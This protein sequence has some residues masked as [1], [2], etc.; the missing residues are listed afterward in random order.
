M[1]LEIL[2]A[3]NVATAVLATL[4]KKA[5]DKGVD[6]A[7][8]HFFETQQGRELTLDRIEAKVDALRR[9]PLNVGLSWLEVAAAGDQNESERRRAVDLALEKFMDAQGQLDGAARAS[10]LLLVAFAFQLRGQGQEHARWLKKCRAFADEQIQG[11]LA[12]A[13]EDSHRILR[14]L[15]SRSHEIFFQTFKWANPLISDLND[16]LC[17]DPILWTHAVE[18]DTIMNPNDG[19][20]IVV[21][22]LIISR[23][24][25]QSGCLG[26]PSETSPI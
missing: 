25:E 18:R 14:R 24:G 22:S 17:D 19:E 3:S 5:V 10:A 4:K 21:Y 26:I 9:G 11:T 2:I 20:I 23:N 12:S 1:S 15:F 16:V 13:R 7:L 6:A 8:K